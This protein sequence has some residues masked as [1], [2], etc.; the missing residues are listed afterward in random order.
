M[1]NVAVIYGGK[2]VEHDISVITALQV[3][4]AFP[5]QY[6]LIPIYIK[7]DG[8]MVSADNL[9]D[10]K[11]YLDYAKNVKRER[12][13]V[14]HSGKAQ[15]SFLKNGKVVRNENISAALLCT[16]GHGGEDG[17]LQGLLEMCDIPYSSPDVPSSAICMDKMLTKCVL[18][19]NRIDSPTYV[20]IDR[21]GFETEKEKFE[22][23]I[24]KDVS[25][26]CIIKP[27][28]CGSSVGI[29]IC[30]NEQLFSMCMENAFLYDDKVI[31]EQYIDNAKEYFCAIL[32]FSQKLIASKVD[33]AKKGDFYTF[34]EKYLKS[35]SIDK[36]EISPSLATRIQTM[37]KET[38]TAL[39]CDGVVRVDFLYDEEADKL[40]VNEV[41]TI[42]GSLAYN[43]FE[44]KIED[45]LNA[46]IVSAKEKQKKS[47]N[48]VYKFNSSAIEKYLEIENCEK[49]KK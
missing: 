45:F 20:H 1:E 10:G 18:G 2:S 34:E 15:T 40:Y 23:R 28:R 38:F 27:A 5:K 14:F 30:A 36:A 41:N 17:S 31:V 47:K 29:S 42:P 46:L 39:E 16:H 6:N 37:A 32:S 22:K 21:C 33:Q 35:K 25:F 4:K 48:I 12:E 44:T 7:Q 24:R 8:K 49:Y 11:V 13:I 43:L 9:T 19:K 26:P 3:M